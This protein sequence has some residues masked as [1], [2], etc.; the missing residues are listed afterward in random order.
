MVLDRVF[1]V[2][3]EAE[4]LGA[5]IAGKHFKAS[6]ACNGCGWCACHCPSGN[7]QLVNHKPVFGK[8]CHLCLSCVYGCPQKAVQIGMGKFIAIKEGFSLKAL[9]AQVPYPAEVDVEELAKGYLWSGIKKYLLDP[10]A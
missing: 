8:K 7:I 2:I 3:G 10:D 4:K 6:V 1:S 9:E 5:K